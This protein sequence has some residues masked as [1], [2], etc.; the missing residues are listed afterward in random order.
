MRGLD[1]D[2]NALRV[3]IIPNAFCNLGGQPLRRPGVRPNRDPA[4]RAID[5]DIA[6]DAP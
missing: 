2:R 1:H 6:P 4:A 5:L 3:Q